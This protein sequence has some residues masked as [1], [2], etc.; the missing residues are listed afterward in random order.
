[1]GRFLGGI[2]ALALLAAGARGEES[3]WLTEYG[4]AKERAAAEHKPILID[5]TGSDWCPDCAALE[6]NVLSTPTFLSYAKKNLVLLRIDFPK[7]KTLP[8]DVQQRNAALWWK[9]GAHNYPSVILADAEEKVLYRGNDQPEGPGGFVAL[10]RKASPPEAA[11]AKEEGDAF[12]AFAAQ[13]DAGP[14]PSP[15]PAPAPSQP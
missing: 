8:P 1:M 10:L 5:F 15:A 13:P 4:P 12:A 11:P 6:A 14:S 2:A 9:F 3:L 7:H